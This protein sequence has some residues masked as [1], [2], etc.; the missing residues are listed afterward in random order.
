MTIDIYSHALGGKWQKVYLPWDT[1]TSVTTLPQEYRFPNLDVTVDSLNHKTLPVWEL[2]FNLCTDS[3]LDGVH[4]FGLWDKKSSTMRIYS[5]IEDGIDH[6]YCYYIVTSQGAS[7]FVE[8]D[9]MVWQP[10]DSIIKKGNWNSVAIA[11]ADAR[12]STTQFEAMPI[13]G[14]LNGEVN[15]GWLCFELNLSAGN[16]R[17]PSN[18]SIS[19]SLEA[20]DQIDLRGTDSLDLSLDCKNCS[21]QG[22]ITIPGNKQKMAGGVTTAIGDLVSGLA[23]AVTQ[24]VTVGKNSGEK[25][26][27][28]AVGIASAAGALISYAG[29]TTTAEALQDSTN[30]KARL[31]LGLNF[32]G[33]ANGR[34]NGQL[35]S[36]FST[37]VSPVTMSYGTLFDSLLVSRDSKPAS[38]KRNALYPVNVPSSKI[39]FGRII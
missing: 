25:E 33:N 36:H 16:Y 13:T 30:L 38:I 10:S 28:I 21:I 18:A 17:I 32:N 24:G 26:L 3:L 19:F 37:Q 7:C 29:K 39:R 6:T 11:D 2:A 8:R 9:A 1:T 22:K 15:R 31:S 34:F 27:G 4:M 20:V 14:T 35:K 5:Y 23:T 12:P